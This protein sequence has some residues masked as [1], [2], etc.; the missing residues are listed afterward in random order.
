M[1]HNKTTRKIHNFI[2]ISCI[3]VFGCLLILHS[4]QVYK[5]FDALQLLFFLLGLFVI[6]FLFYSIISLG[7]LFF[8]KL[9]GYK[10]AFLR[11]AFLKW[12]KDKS[13]K[14]RVSFADDNGPVSICKMYPPEMK[15]GKIPYRLYG[16][17]VVILSSILICISAIALT[18]CFYTPIISSLLLVFIFLLLII[19]LLELYDGNARHT[20]DIKKSPLA[21]KGLWIS[22]MLTDPEFSTDE[23]SDFPDDADAKIYWVAFYGWV[24]SSTL[25]EK[26]N[27]L[28]A[29]KVLDKLR[30]SDS[31][32]LEEMY[33]S[34]LTDR[35]FC[36]VMTHNNP[37]IITE[38]YTDELKNYLSTRRG[39]T[40]L[41]RNYAFTL[42]IDKNPSGAAQI[43]AEFFEA[44]KDSPHKSDVQTETE[45]L[46]LAE[47]KYTNDN[48]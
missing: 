2:F 31:G 28:E 22:C 8:G 40:H 44:A 14:I 46:L 15:D 36:E 18:F 4:T 13:G 27:F 19:I 30:K 25:M 32:L 42:L 24:C 33:F 37:E 29:A 23:Y 26:K 3:L 35:L 16:Y 34:M 47:N 20:R 43:K 1:S 12:Q 41:C 17:G 39:Y 38:L 6:Q 11:I 5:S 10:M 48:T 7:F 21:L 45:L 9:T